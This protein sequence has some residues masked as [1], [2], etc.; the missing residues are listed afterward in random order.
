[1][2]TKDKLAEALRDAG[3]PTFMIANAE[4]GYYDDFE[5]DL[6]CPITTLVFDCEANGLPEIAKRA[7]DGDFDGTLE[8]AEA[9][10]KREGIP[11]KFVFD[12][13]E[14]KPR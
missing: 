9:W 1:M 13:Y 7:I 5:S 8:E 4:A 3:A 2:K 14:Q 11:A 6:P 12:W 10:A